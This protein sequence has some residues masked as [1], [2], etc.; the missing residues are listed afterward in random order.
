MKLS[1]LVTS[2]IRLTRW[3][4]KAQA[5]GP[6]CFAVNRHSPQINPA[7]FTTL[8]LSTNRNQERSNPVRALRPGSKRTEQGPTARRTG[9]D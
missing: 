1:L 4:Q 7:E 3:R 5:K 6:A 9:W 8:R 2:G